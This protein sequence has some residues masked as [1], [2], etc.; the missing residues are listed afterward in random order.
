[1]SF[2]GRLRKEDYI[3]YPAAEGFIVILVLS[4]PL[5]LS[6][7]FAFCPKRFSQQSA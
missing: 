2:D 6:G 4:E 3:L 7:Q 5:C 1:M